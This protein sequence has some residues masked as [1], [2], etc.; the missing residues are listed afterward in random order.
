MAETLLPTAMVPG[1]VTLEDKDGNRANHYP[2]DAK[3]LLATGEFTLVEN[4]AIEAARMAATPLRSGMVNIPAE[5]IVAE[6]AGHAGMIIAHDDPAEVERIIASGDNAD[7][8]GRD[9]K[10]ASA[11]ARVSENKSAAKSAASTTDKEKADATKLAA[12]QSGS[13]TKQ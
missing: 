8:T 1:L 13:T 6:V 2:V 10:A 12:S 3:E 7:G 9:P 4:G 5:N 11:D